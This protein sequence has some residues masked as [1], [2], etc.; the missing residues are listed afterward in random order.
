MNIYSFQIHS[1]SVSSK[2][3]FKMAIKNNI[4]QF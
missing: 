1:N 3:I 2:Y 4:N